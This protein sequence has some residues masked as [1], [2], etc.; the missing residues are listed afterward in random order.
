MWCFLTAALAS[1]DILFIGTFVSVPFSILVGLF[2][3]K[4]QFKEHCKFI[5]TK[6]PGNVPY[7]GAVRLLEFNIIRTG[8]PR[9]ED[10]S[11][12]P[13]TR[14]SMGGQRSSLSGPWTSTLW[15]CS[16]PWSLR[17]K[18]KIWIRNWLLF[19][20]AMGIRPGCE[21]SGPVFKIFPYHRKTP[22]APQISPSSS[23]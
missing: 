13:G 16:L 23:L 5:C 4:T 22:M 12:W 1:Q 15:L 20:A 14:G 9:M 8:S 11:G 2:H 19:P 18:V 17:P 3:M 10:P 21:I 6:R 7:L